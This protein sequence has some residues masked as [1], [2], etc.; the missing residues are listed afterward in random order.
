LV[1]V[2]VAHVARDLLDPALDRAEVAAVMRRRRTVAKR[3]LLDQTLVSGVGNIYADEALWR[4]RLHGE[5]PTAAF[6]R[7]QALALLDAAAEVMAEALA[8]GGTSFDALYVNVNGASGYF[9][10]SLAVYGQADR[11]CPRCGT[12][13]V[14]EQFMNR[15][16][17][18]CPLC[19]PRP[20]RKRT[21]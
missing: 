21:P 14:R 15:S 5:R 13:V 7:A 16:S 11:P 10:R 9:S 4:A 8:A 12:L 1:P 2:P 3:A 18:S 17:Y 6:T 20:R 19:Q